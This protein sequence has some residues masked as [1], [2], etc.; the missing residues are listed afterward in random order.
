MISLKALRTWSSSCK[1]VESLGSR[2]SNVKLL[3]SYPAGIPSPEESTCLHL[4]AG[5]V[6]ASKPGQIL[7]EV[8]S[9]RLLHREGRQGGGILQPT[10]HTGVFHGLWKEFALHEMSCCF[11]RHLEQTK[12]YLP[13]PPAS[14]ISKRMHTPWSVGVGTDTLGQWSRGENEPFERCGCVLLSVRSTGFLVCIPSRMPSSLTR[15][16]CT[17][18][19]HS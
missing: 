15:T 7:L 9:R 6:C 1:R 14:I 10:K 19:T 2:I 4:L 11:I 12:R 13:P 5:G 8:G 16:Y 17:F 3:F 18:H